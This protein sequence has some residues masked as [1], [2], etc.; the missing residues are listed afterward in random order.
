M[1]M[2]KVWEHSEYRLFQ[3]QLTKKILLILFCGEDVVTTSFDWD[4]MIEFID[5]NVNLERNN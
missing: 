2:I 4:E 3:L 1:K 5:K